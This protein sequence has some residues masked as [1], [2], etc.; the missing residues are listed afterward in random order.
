[1]SLNRELADLFSSMADL[2]DLRGEN[3][4]KSLAFRKVGRILKDLT[5]DIRQAV[6][7]GTVADMEGI[8]KHSARIIAEYVTTNQSSDYDELAGSVPAGLIPLLQVEGLGPKTVALLWKQRNITGADELLAAIEKGDLAGIKGIG[9]KKIEN[10]RRG[11]ELRAKAGGRK[12]IAEVWPIA[13]DLLE[14]LRQLPQVK[15]AEVAGSLRRGR[16]T[17]G[18]VDLLCCVAEASAMQS[19]A[20]AFVRFPLVERVLGHGATKVSVVTA[21][22]LQVDLRVIAVEHF[23][24]AMLYFTGSKEHNV[25]I[26]GLAQKRARTLNEWGLYDVEDYEKS[27]KRTAEAPAAT[28]IASR[29]EADIYNR[30]GLR[31]IEPEL[32]EDRGEVEAAMDNRLPVL[33]AREDICGDLHTHTTA[34]DGQNSIEEMA[35]SAKALGYQYLAITDHSKSQVI[36]NGLTAERLLEHVKAVR[37]VASRMKGITLL[38]GSEVDILADGRLDYE[39]EVLSELD[40][41]I[42]SPHFALKQDARKATDRMLRAIDARYVN[43][44]GHPTGRLIGGREGLPL[45]MAA[46]FKTAAG[47]GTAMEINAG[48]PRLDLNEHHARMAVEAGVMLSIN[49]DAH[50]TRE[51]GRNELGISTARRGWVTAKAVINCLDNNGLRS[52]LARKR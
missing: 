19:V 45:D 25:K 26:R 32:R 14:R 5:F 2:M 47:N 21:T 18:D 34:S 16:E 31:F 13:V 44:I 43:I 15:Q 1:M 3:A 30:L 22:G 23:G 12:G 46:L 40:L 38:A 52:F 39:P 9:E 49:T 37:E 29:S 41:V 42:A 20:D 28:P 48:Y 50:S 35:E 11:L 51:L 6:E 7:Q 36:A 33:I 27:G 10:I 17:I 24:A 8:G 4:F